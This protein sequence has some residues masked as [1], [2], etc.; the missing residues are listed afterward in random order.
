MEKPEI[1]FFCE[2]PGDR[3]LD[4]FKDPRI[5]EQLIDLKARVSLGMMDLSPERAEVVRRLNLALVPVTAWLLLPKE[6]G[7]WFN[8]DNAPQ[9]QR[10]YG[11]FKQWAQVNQLEF[12]GIGL[13]IEPDIHLMQRLVKEP[14]RISSRLIGRMFNMRRVR[15]AEV[16]YRALVAQ[17]RMDGYFVESYQFPIIIDER[18]TNSHLLQSMFGV[19]DLPVDREVLMLYSSMMGSHGRAILESYAESAGGI[20]LGSTGGGVE[21]E[22]T[23]EARSYGWEDLQKDLLLASRYNQHIHIFSLEGC[24]RQDMLSKMAGMDWTQSVSAP[25][26]QVR[27]VENIRKTGQVVLWMGARP[28]LIAA[29]IGLLILL[30]GGKKRHTK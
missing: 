3:L 9:A 25:A 29:G 28:W 5:L 15:L 4:L 13:D 16:D 20:G 11:R 6:E 23:G 14:V 7:Y 26:E 10:F 8:L 22:G 18:R 12:A 24:L 27:V 19:L 30:L 17:I 1:T 21:L 2:L